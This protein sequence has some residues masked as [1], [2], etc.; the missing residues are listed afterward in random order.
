[1]AQPQILSAIRS[2]WERIARAQNLTTQIRTK[3]EPETVAAK[4]IRMK[5]AKALKEFLNDKTPFDQVHK[6]LVG[7]DA[8]I[9]QLRD[10]ANS[11][12]ET[13]REERKTCVKEA[14]M[15]DLAV[16]HTVMSD[17]KVSP[18]SKSEI[19]EIVETE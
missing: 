3:T 1:M 5:K 12:T 17:P 18:L 11:K 8:K 15:L 6:S 19:A 4:K 14:K 16:A 7:F 10:S 2:R 9:K 13:E